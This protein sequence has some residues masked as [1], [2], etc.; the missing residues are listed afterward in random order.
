MTEYTY[1][2]TVPADS[3]L[4]GLISDLVAQ[5]KTDL[6]T[7]NLPEPPDFKLDTNIP[8]VTS[9]LRQPPAFSATVPTFKVAPLTGL[10]RATYSALRSVYH[11]NFNAPILPPLVY[12]QAKHHIALPTTNV[13]AP[14]TDYPVV[15]YVDVPQPTNIPDLPTTSI[16]LGTRPTLENLAPITFTPTSLEPLDFKLS[17]DDLSSEQIDLP[18]LD[19]QPFVDYVGDEEL[20]QVIKGWLQSNP[21]ELQTWAAWQG[22]LVESDTRKLKYEVKEAISK[23]F[24][25]AAA[26]NFALPAGFVDAEVQQVAQKEI[27]A[28]SDAAEKVYQE[29]LASAVSTL[30]QAVRSALAV[31]QYHFQLYVQYVKRNYQLY[32]LNLQSAQL[33]YNNLAAIFDVFTRALAQHIDNYNQYVNAVLAQNQAQF[34][35][36]D[37]LNGV[38]DNYKAQITL[39]RADVATQKAQ[40]D[41]Q[42][43]KAEHATLRLDAY[44]SLLRGILANYN[45]LETNLKSYRQA[46]ENY[47]QSYKLNESKLDAYETAIR[48]E[49]SAGNVVEANVR[50]YA[51]VIGMERQRAGAYEEY[52]RRSTDAIELEIQNMRQAIDTE[53]SYLSAVNNILSANMQ[54][55][56]AYESSVGNY[57]RAFEAS[58]R[59][60]AGYT[61]NKNKL[62]ILA[63]ETRFTQASLNNTAKLYSAKLQSAL[64]QIRIRAGGA[65]AQAAST[66]Y[67][68]G[69]A[70]NA[71]AREDVQG[72]KSYAER[73]SDD[74]T[75]RWSRTVRREI[76]PVKY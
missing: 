33:I 46:I 53:Q 73:T 38:I 16:T 17:L 6:P 51:Q 37:M 13:T 20:K 50:T 61:A 12:E 25:Q 75:K 27:E 58:E 57:L 8:S 24:E 1:G 5:I 59:A 60:K 41:V 2:F 74:Y 56:S 63:E 69:V 7:P 35:Q 65:L 66:I 55:L 40:A 43:I 76:R 48:A 68:V 42:A 30:S 70:A 52:V 4:F 49:A 19:F 21:S 62:D 39:Y 28:Q 10:A 44:G 72:S 23:I 71:S 67:N 54:I 18:P 9:Q 34:A 36:V 15:G 11:F 31:E 64:A 47:A 14:P 32:K 3:R 26:R 45:I 29:M 22:S